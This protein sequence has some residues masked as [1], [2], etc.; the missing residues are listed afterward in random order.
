MGVL[1]YARFGAA[2]EDIGSY[3]SCYLGPGHLGPVVAVHRTHA[4]RR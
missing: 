4:G 1:G 3:V 2:G